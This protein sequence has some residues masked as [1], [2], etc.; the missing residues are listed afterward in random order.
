MVRAYIDESE[1]DDVFIMAG[2]VARDSI[3]AAFDDDWNATLA[4]APAIRYF[5]H[6]EAK[7]EPPKGQFAGWSADD[8]EKKVGA[9]AEVVARHE[10]YGVNT[11]LWKSKW[12]AAFAG[13]QATP[14]QLRS[15]LKFTHHFAACFFTIHSDVLNLELERH[16][17]EPVDCVFDDCETLL[18]ECIELLE[19]Q[20]ANLPFTLKPLC[21]EIQKGNDKTTPGLQAADLLAGQ[22]TNQ[23]RVGRTELPFRR[24]ATAHN[25]YL[26]NA[27][28]PFMPPI[29]GI[30]EHFNLVW[31]ALQDHRAAQKLV[32][33]RLSSESTAA[34]APA[35]QSQ[36]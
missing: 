31:E 32:A 10:M 7:S 36:E 24:M 29:P 9:L 4:A 33:N 8:V 17:T 2:W 19:S 14:R 12:N 13:T 20:R 23:L 15:I 21:G 28:P 27:Y 5:K 30:V 1:R 18:D 16:Q 3:W 35:P 11:G 34:Q 25:I 26:T 22:L 6:N